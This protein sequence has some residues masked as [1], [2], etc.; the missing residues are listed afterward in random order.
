MRIATHE[1]ALAVLAAERAQL[2][3]QLDIL[4]AER[5]VMEAVAR[6]LASTRRSSNGGGL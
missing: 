5:Q 4:R 3:K 6:K 2:S 1:T